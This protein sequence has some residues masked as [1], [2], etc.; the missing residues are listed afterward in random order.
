MAG[1]NANILEEVLE[2]FIG[3]AE[4][5][6]HLALVE[7]TFVESEIVGT[8]IE[9]VYI[10]IIKFWV[11]AIDYY[12]DKISTSEAGVPTAVSR[13]SSSYTL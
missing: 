2:F 11:K 7:D 6:R 3:I 1:A 4:E 5:I 9:A 12:T 8:A 13:Y 10:A